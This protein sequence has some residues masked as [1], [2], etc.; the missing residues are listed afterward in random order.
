MYKIE[1]KKYK[2][3]DYPQAESAENKEHPQA[4]LA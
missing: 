4:R 1:K 2:H 3:T